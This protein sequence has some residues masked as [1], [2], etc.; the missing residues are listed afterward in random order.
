[1]TVKTYQPNLVSVSFRGVPITGFAPDTFVSA[2]RNNDSWSINVGSGGDATRTK[3]GDKSGRVELT[4]LAESESN[5]ILDA[6]AKTDEASG[7]GL[8]PLGIKDLSGADVITAGTAWIVKPPDQEKANTGSNRVWMFE[9]DNLEITN[10][11]IPTL[12]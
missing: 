10:A 2:T 12:P 3:S 9:T 5:A 11:G 6:F 4:L 7:L 1:M 8:G